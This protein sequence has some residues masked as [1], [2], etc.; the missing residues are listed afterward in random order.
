[1]RC[2]IIL[3]VGSTKSAGEKQALSP[4][5]TAATPNMAKAIKVV[6]LIFQ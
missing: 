4:P 5:W 6:K 1:M 2:K 3:G